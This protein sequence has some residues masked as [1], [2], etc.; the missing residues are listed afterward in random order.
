[1]FVLFL[2]NVDIMLI[3]FKMLNQPYILGINST[4]LWC[5]ILFICCRIHFV[6]VLYRISVS[7]FVRDMIWS[8]VFLCLLGYFWP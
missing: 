8:V 7:L 4:W 2:I 3:D 1:M 6:D 5:I